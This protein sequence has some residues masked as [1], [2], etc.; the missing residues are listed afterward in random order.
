MT[1]NSMIDDILEKEGGFV[2]HPNDKGGATNFGITIKTLA[3]WRK[4]LCSEY[5]VQNMKLSEARDIY[6]HEYYSGP[7]INQ[8]PELIQPVLFDMAVNH[9]PKRAIIIL[10]QVLNAMLD[11]ELVL[12]GK[13]GPRTIESA[14]AAVSVYNK[15]V[16]KSLVD[17]RKSFYE[18]IC[19]ND[20]DQSVFLK[21][22]LAR[23]ESFIA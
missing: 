19:D 9:G 17:A 10:Q 20:P 6:R 1:I 16:I 7:K 4:H 22:W 14:R 11:I 13:L 5:D 18:S 21:G 12:D 2:N 15:D 23:A 3:A 8:L